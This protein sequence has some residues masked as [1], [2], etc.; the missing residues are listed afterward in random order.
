MRTLLRFFALSILVFGFG[1]AWHFYIPEAQHSEPQL[2]SVQ[3]TINET[4]DSIAKI[5]RKYGDNDQFTARSDARH[6]AESL[7]TDARNSAAD[8]RKRN[9]QLAIVILVSSGIF[10][11]GS[12]IASNSLR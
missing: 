10:A 8:L 3:Q 5:S 11:L 4:E 7:R 12:F 6:A 2:S 1:L 9:N